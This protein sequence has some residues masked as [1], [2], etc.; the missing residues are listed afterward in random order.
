MCKTVERRLG[1]RVE[2]VPAARQIVAS[3]LEGWGAVSD[4]PAAELRDDAVLIVT[5]LV[6]NAVK[7]CHELLTLKVESHREW[8]EIAVA[9]DSPF[10]AVKLEPAPDSVGGRGLTI[11][12]ALSSDW[13]QA[14]FDGMQKVVWSRLPLPSGS[15]LGADCRL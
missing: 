11:V 3:V 12:E 9:D 4:D 15:A 13:G 10:P 8:L 7:M 6:T 2:S 14:P 5:E 1:C